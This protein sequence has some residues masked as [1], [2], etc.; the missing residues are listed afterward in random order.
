MWTRLTS[1]DTSTFG[2]RPIPFGKKKSSRT[3]IGGLLFDLSTAYISYKTCP[4]D[5]DGVDTSA[6]SRTVAAS[7][8][9]QVAQA[10]Y[11]S[12][13]SPWNMLGF[14]EGDV[15]RHMCSK[16]GVGDEGGAAPDEW[17]VLF[18]RDIIC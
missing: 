7:R 14:V 2:S 12:L 3:W 9:T 5:K 18:H 17:F 11:Y 16:E 6:R 1:L 8:C 10:V 15:L 4:V 13:S